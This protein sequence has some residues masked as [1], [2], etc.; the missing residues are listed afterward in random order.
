M[1]FILAKPWPSVSGIPVQP[2]L[3]R[4]YPLDSRSTALTW[5]KL[6]ML[7]AV[8]ESNS[9]I[10]ETFSMSED[11]CLAGSPYLTCLEQSNVPL[12]DGVTRWWQI[13]Y[14]IMNFTSVVHSQK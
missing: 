3:T 10:F 14:N 9:N 2:L 7:I 12:L 1:V 8:A 13:K 11:I 6:C 4:F 5:Y